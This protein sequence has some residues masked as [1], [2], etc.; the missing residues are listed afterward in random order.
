MRPDPQWHRLIRDRLRGKTRFETWEH[1]TDLRLLELRRL[2]HILNRDSLGALLELGCGNAIGS[3]FF[4]PQSTK[5]VATDLGEA[6]PINHSIGLDKA[7]NVFAELNIRNGSIRACSAEELP[8]ESSSFDTIISLHCLEHVPRRDAA[9]GECLR[10]LKSG[11]KVAMLVPSMGYFALYP[12]DFYSDLCRRGIKRILKKPRQAEVQ[13][14]TS[15]LGS[16]E[17]VVKDWNSFRKYY[18]SFPLPQPHGTFPTYFHELAMSPGKWKRL[19][20]N[21]GFLNVKVDPVSIIPLAITNIGAAG[22]R[23]F[24]YLS[25]MDERLCRFPLS[26]WLAQTICITAEKEAE[27]ES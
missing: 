5:V 25:Q 2:A 26:L 6:D 10:V 7:H 4:S 9:L 15:S 21:A 20:V 3:A 17:H 23:L 27:A 16:P 11:G 8:F 22:M 18:S 19:F 24:L 12:I 1:H 14:S 13:D